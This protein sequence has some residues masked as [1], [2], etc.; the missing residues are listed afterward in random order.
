[1][2]GMRIVTLLLALSLPLFGAS[3]LP[4]L[5]NCWTF[6]DTVYGINTQ[7]FQITSPAFEPGL[8]GN[9][10]R[11][12][13]TPDASGTAIGT[14]TMVYT[15]DWTGMVWV[16]PNIISGTQTVLDNVTGS[17]V[18]RRGF[19]LQIQSTGAV[20]LVVHGGGSVFNVATSIPITSGTWNCVL[21]GY[22]A[23]T[24]KSF[25]RVNDVQTDHPGVVL[26]GG[27]PP[28]NLRIGSSLDGVLDNLALWKGKVL[29]ATEMSELYNSGTGVDYPF[30]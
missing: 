14:V 3:K 2:S 18:N 13:S 7:P 21:F 30:P 25:I 10:L 1:M 4:H 15:Q 5:Y 17:G 20:V 22:N 26:P 23:T 6:D 8:F 19:S 24:L 16:N 9:G 12:N 29:T 11:C 28:A 27:G